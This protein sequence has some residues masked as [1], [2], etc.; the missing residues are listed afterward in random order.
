MAILSG[1]KYRDL[2][3]KF[4]DFGQPPV[5]QGEAAV[6]S[7]IRNL[8]T[9]SIGSRSRT[10]NQ[11]WGSSLMEILQEPISQVTAGALQAATMASLKTWEPRVTLIESR[12]SF[13]PNYTLPG[14][15]VKLVYKI[16]DANTV[17]AYVLSLEV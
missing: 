9:S 6:R 16:N 3:V 8:L 13:I 14:Y 1:V 2:N 4:G 10:F 15:D 5:L 12:C 7:S 17:Y 11:R